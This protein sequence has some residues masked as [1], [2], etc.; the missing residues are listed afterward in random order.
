M[1]MTENKS[2]SLYQLLLILIL[3]PLMW[4]EDQPGWSVQ[5]VYFPQLS[6]CM[7]L[8]LVTFLVIT[9]TKYVIKNYFKEERFVFVYTFRDFTLKS[10]TPCVW[11]VHHGSGNLWQRRFLRKP[12]VWNTGSFWVRCSG[13]ALWR[14]FPSARPHFLLLTTLP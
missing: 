1:N 11:S 8:G 3:P 5:S 10:L 2:C 7:S 12:R 14:I 4:S 13:Y 6:P 9:I